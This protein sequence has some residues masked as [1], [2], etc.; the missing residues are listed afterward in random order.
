MYSTRPSV[1]I[2][3]RHGSNSS[4]RSSCSKRVTV[5]GLSS[6]NH[7]QYCAGVATC[8]ARSMYLGCVPSTR[9]SSSS[10]DFFR[11]KNG[12]LENSPRW[13]PKFE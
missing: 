5:M 12:S 3:T 6:L 4:A 10:R 11:W 9:R 13:W 2:A 7:C 1:R 8:P